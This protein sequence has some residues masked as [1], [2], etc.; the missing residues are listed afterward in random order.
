MALPSLMLLAAAVTCST[1]GAGGSGPTLG[2]TSGPTIRTLPDD[3]SRPYAITA[4]DYHF[5]DAHP[6]VDLD[7]ERAVTFSNQGSVVHNVT[8]P[9]IRYSRDIRPGE[10][11][12]IEALGERLGG[13]GVYE[14]YCAYHTDRGMR[15]TLVVG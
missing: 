13:A 8:I 10:R 5:H 4:I 9:A 3:T 2:A 6:T 11:I 1:A 14:L 12:T 15:G 7:P